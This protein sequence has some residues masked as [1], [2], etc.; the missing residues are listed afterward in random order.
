MIVNELIKF[1]FLYLIILFALF[2]ISI[3]DSLNSVNIVEAFKN[4][5]NYVIIEKT[6]LISIVVFILFK[7]VAFTKFIIKSLFIFAVI[8][9]LIYLWNIGFF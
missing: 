7:F 9:A 8:L 5:I 4:F 6:F 2:I 1:I 3:S